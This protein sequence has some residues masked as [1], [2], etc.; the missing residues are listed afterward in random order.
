MKAKTDN[1]LYDKKLQKTLDK[2]IS[3]EMIASMF[4]TACIQA[5]QKSDKHLIEEMFTEIAID[6]L[7]DHMKHLVEWATA[8]DY[9]VPYKFKDF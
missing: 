1:P 2:L 7:S 6:E 8:N 9:S 4:Y 5:V 3:E